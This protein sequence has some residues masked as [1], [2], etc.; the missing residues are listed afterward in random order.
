M[1]AMTKT[2]ENALAAIPLGHVEGQT[3]LKVI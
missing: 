1:Q 3:I 2:L